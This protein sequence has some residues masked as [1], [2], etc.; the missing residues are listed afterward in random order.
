MS[1]EVQLSEAEKRKERRVRHEARHDGGY[2]TA[3]EVRQRQR[4]IAEAQMKKIQMVIT[5]WTRDQFGNRSR[6]IYRA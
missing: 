3:E 6:M 4:Q 2:A 1:E 5:P